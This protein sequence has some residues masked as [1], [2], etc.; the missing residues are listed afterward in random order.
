M[1]TRRII[2][3]LG[4]VARTAVGVDPSTRHAQW[5][6]KYKNPRIPPGQSTTYHQPQLKSK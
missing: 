2:S 3:F 5:A 6:H 1:R 4:E